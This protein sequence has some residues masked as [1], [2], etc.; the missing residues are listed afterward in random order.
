MKPGSGET[1][2]VVDGTRRHTQESRRLPDAEPGKVTHHHDLHLLWSHMFQFLQRLVEGN[3]SAGSVA[4]SPGSLSSEPMR[5][6]SRGSDDGWPVPWARVPQNGDTS[7]GS[8]TRNRADPRGV[9]GASADGQGAAAPRRPRAKA[10]L[11]RPARRL[12]PGAA[13]PNPATAILGTVSLDELG[14]APHC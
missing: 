1:P 13:S 3:S 6:L 10:R 7:R 14:L 4:A 8:G 2:V 5:R 12:R 11:L 9:P